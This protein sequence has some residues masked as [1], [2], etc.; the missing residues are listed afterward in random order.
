VRAVTRLP[1]HAALRPR[2]IESCCSETAKYLCA[3]TK[4]SSHTTPGFTTV[5][6][7]LLRTSDEEN[8]TSAACLFDTSNSVARI[9]IWQKM[10]STDVQYTPV[11]QESDDSLGNEPKLPPRRHRWEAVGFAAVVIAVVMALGLLAASQTATSE[12]SCPQPALRRE[13]RALSTAEQSEYLRAVQCL[14]DLPSGLDLGGKLSDDFPWLHFTAG[15]YGEWSS[16]C[17][18]Q[19][20]SGELTSLCD[21]QPMEMRRFCRGIGG[22]SIYTRKHSRKAVVTLVTSC[23]IT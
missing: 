13:W 8:Q 21:K 18:L 22:S 11:A 7:A 1:T 3:P 23:M 4:G 6:L 12:P 5:F 15:Q 9:H 19:R 10:I 17:C 20:A 14:H 2:S 16:L